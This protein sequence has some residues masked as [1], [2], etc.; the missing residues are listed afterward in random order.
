MQIT[1]SQI[2]RICKQLKKNPVKYSF[3][4]KGNHNTN[5]VIK[6]NDGNYILRI[7]NNSQFKNLTKEY[8]ILKSLKSGLGPKIYFFDHSHKIIPADYFV[9]EFIEGKHP[10]E[11][12]N[13]SFAKKMA[14][15]LKKLHSTRTLSLSECM[16][17]GYYSLSCAIKPYYNNFEKY[18]YCLNAELT[19]TLEILFQKT[20]K[21]SKN[22]DKLFYGL[23]KF[24]LLHRDLSKDNILITKDAVKLIDWEFAGPG[25]PEWDLVY[26]LQSFK[27]TESQK[28]L[29]LKEYGYPNNRTAKTKLN[30]IS[31]LNVCGGIG[32]SVWRLGL[33]KE[34]KLNQKEKHP[35]L[36]RLNQDIKLVKKIIG[37][38]E[39]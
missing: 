10:K 33:I 39:K 23:K 29:F 31:L 27:H 12:L 32:Y 7:E 13:N 30:M 24:P 38:L 8:T 14:R 37:D 6:T 5:Y 1:K 11:K 18:H 21:L 20:I 28:N 34:G 15:W 2:E 3:L 16:S 4:A 22:N 36:R 9:E 35:A 17:K 25:V 26:F 19:Q